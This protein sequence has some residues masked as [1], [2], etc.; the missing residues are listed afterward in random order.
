M[1][2]RLWHQT[3]QMIS[4]IERH[5]IA[6]HKAMKQMKE[7]RLHTILVRYLKAWQFHMQNM[8]W[9]QLSLS[10][11]SRGIQKEESV[12]CFCQATKRKEQATSSLIVDTRNASQ[13]WMKMEL[14]VTFK[15]LQDGQWTWKATSLL[16][17]HRRS[18]DRRQLNTQLICMKV[19][20]SQLFNE[21]QTL[22]SSS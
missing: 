21:I 15:I 14:I 18:G 11:L 9:I 7:A 4:E 1:G 17:I 6:I 16:A 22:T 3:N 2:G 8:T 19:G 12:R 20:I 5:S 13:I 10:F